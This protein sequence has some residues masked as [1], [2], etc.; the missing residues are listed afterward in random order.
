MLLIEQSEQQYNAFI[1]KAAF[2]YGFQIGKAAFSDTDSGSLVRHRRAHLCH[3][4]SQFL[5]QTCRDRQ[6]MAIEGN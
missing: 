4:L 1:T 3:T 5:Y 2:E 6:R